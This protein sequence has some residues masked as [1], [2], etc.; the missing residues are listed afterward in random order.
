MKPHLLYIEAI[1]KNLD[2]KLSKEEI[3]KLPK[4]LFLAYS[5]QYR[6]LAKKI[7]S[8]LE[9]NKIKVVDFQQVLGCSKVNTKLPILLVSTGKFHLQN[10]MLSS[11]IIYTLVIPINLSLR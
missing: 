8:Q 1:R 9:S 4:K 7:K 10:L 2:V 6:E 5:V 3:A 11:P